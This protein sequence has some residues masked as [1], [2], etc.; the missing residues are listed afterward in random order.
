[1]RESNCRAFHRIRC[2]YERFLRILVTVI[3]VVAAGC[4]SF[5]ICKPLQDDV[6]LSS[7]QQ[8]IFGKA[9]LPK[10]TIDERFREGLCLLI[11]LLSQ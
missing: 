3:L 1:M 4:F 10:T 5:M 9:H 6:L 2:C 11:R 8:T 7:D